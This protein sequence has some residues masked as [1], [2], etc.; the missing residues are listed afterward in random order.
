MQTLLPTTDTTTSLFGIE[1]RGTFRV[2]TGSIERA[3]DV[4]ADESGRA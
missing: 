4:V 1:A 3:G 2:S